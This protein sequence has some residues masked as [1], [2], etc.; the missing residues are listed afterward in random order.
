METILDE[1][2]EEGAKKLNEGDLGA[3]DAYETLP[4]FAVRSL[5]QRLRFHH[6]VLIRKRMKRRHE[7]AARFRFHFHEAE[8]G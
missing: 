3:M 7:Q 2:L 8:R 6:R 1:R 4:Y 5:D